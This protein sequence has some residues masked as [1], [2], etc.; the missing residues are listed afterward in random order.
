VLSDKEGRIIIVLAGR[1]S[2]E[3]WDDVIKGLENALASARDRAVNG[4]VKK[5]TEVCETRGV[6]AITAGYSHGG[7]T[8]V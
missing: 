7:G 4:H 5:A 8:G 3:D 1:P 2:G 6:S